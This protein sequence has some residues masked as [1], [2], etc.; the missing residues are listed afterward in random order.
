MFTDALPNRAERNCFRTRLSPYT[1]IY[2][3][4]STQACTT[5]LS[6]LTH[7]Y[8][9]WI[10]FS[11]RLFT[12]SV[13]FLRLYVDKRQIFFFLHL[14]DEQMD[15]TENCV[16]LAHLS[17]RQAPCVRVVLRP[18]RFFHPVSLWWTVRGG[19]DV[20]IPS[21]A[22]CLSVSASNAI[23]CRNSSITQHLS[24]VIFAVMPIEDTS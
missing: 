19:Q 4:K 9:D 21:R 22:Y 23:A 5:N 12:G 11:I 1:H 13:D 6:T 2:Y 16:R 7:F 10:N 14:Q 15:L 24:V 17:W 3:D 8:S 18:R 20:Q